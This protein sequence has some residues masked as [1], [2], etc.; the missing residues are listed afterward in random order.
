VVV[1]LWFPCF[2]ALVEWKSKLEDC[3]EETQEWKKASE[4]TT[5][6]ENLIVVR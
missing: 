6:L 1:V 5:N 2:S 4:A 3:E